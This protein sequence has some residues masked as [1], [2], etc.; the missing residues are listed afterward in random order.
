[1]DVGGSRLRICT[2]VAQEKAPLRK[3]TQNSRWNSLPR[4]GTGQSKKKELGPFSAK[5]AGKVNLP[6][7]S[8]N[9]SE[10]P[11]SVEKGGN[12][13]ENRS[14]RREKNS[15]SITGK[16]NKE[17]RR[18]SLG[19]QP[20]GYQQS[21]RKTL[22]CPAKGVIG[23]ILKARARIGEKCYRSTQKKNGRK[24]STWTISLVIAR[25]QERKKSALYGGDGG[26]GRKNVLGHLVAVGTLQLFRKGG[27]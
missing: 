23:T 14:A 9:C 25:A 22:S 4:E 8:G 7:S 6:G 11:E 13:L 5:R 21:I 16:E 24:I 19:S 15:T 2:R 20:E 18:S 27:A 26:E 17:C 10:I 3:R 12:Y 1:M